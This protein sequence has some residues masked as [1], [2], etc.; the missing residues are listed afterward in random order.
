[1]SKNTKD[2]KIHQYQYS[3]AVDSVVVIWKVGASWAPLG[4]RQVLRVMLER[5]CISEWKLCA[6]VPSSSARLVTFFMAASERLAGATGSRVSF[7]AANPNLSCFSRSE[8]ASSSCSVFFQ[9]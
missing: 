4:V 9:R 3:T 6:G 1:M 5:S 7:V 2:F 8:D